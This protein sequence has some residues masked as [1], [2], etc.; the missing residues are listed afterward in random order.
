MDTHPSHQNGGP[1]IEP[2]DR[3]LK[4]IGV[5]RVTGWRWRKRGWLR[6]HLIAGRTYITSEERHRF[7][8]M[9]QNGEL[10]GPSTARS[11]LPNN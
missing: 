1:E 10:A 9:V 5:S 6:V 4:R 7:I 2:L 11:L 3:F 8:K